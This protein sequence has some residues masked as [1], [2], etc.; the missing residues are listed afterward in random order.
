MNI[1]IVGSR[2]Y[3]I[4]YRSAAR[5]ILEWADERTESLYMCCQCPHGDGSLGFP[6]FRN[7]INSADMVTPDGMPLV[8]ML[9]LKG[10]KKQKRVYGP[11]LMLHVLER[12]AQEDIPVG[13][14][15]GQT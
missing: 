13:F 3:S 14:Y 2:I 1:A 8:W 9:R 6:D 4:E 5:Q 11:T 7:I 10:R 15:G 12:A